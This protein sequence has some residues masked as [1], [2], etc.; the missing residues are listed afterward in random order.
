MR[1]DGVELE[2]T[3]RGSRHVTTVL[4]CCSTVASTWYRRRVMRTEN[5]GTSTDGSFISGGLF[6]QAEDESRLYLGELVESSEASIVITNAEGRSE[7]T[8]PWVPDRSAFDNA[9]EARSR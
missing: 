6:V 4:H 5:V 2:T 1:Q 8:T 9:I 7:M 3:V